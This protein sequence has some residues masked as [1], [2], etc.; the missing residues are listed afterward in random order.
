MISIR[1]AS[2]LYGPIKLAQIHP[3][4]GLSNSLA[5]QGIR[6]NLVSPRL[7]LI[8]GGHVEGLMKREREER[9]KGIWEDLRFEE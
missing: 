4:K 1:L 8:E 5:S 2:K 9:K 3:A 7:I 6:V